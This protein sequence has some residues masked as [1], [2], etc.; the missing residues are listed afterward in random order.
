MNKYMRYRG[1]F[2]VELALLPLIVA[3][4]LL[5]DT[6]AVGIPLLM[7]AVCRGIMIFIKDPTKVS[8]H[9]IEVVGD[10]IVLEFLAIYFCALGFIPTWLAIV[11]CI[12]V[13]LFQLANVYFYNKPLPDIIEAI[14][15]CFLAFLFTT[16]I[17]LS[18]V[19]VFDVVAKVSFI[20]V[21]LSCG[22]CIVYKLYR[23][24]RYYVIERVGKYTKERAKEEKK[25]SK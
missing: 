12:L 1:L 24:L 23:F 10:A 14:D 17:S 2:A 3:F 21:M 19:V 18:F 4:E 20:A 5:I 25:K 22:I 8:D 13:P 9:I 11:D 16:I 6:W 7:L 15:F